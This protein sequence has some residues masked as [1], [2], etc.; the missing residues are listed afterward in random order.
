MV[1]YTQ[2][3]NFNH[4]SKMQKLVLN[5]ALLMFLLF[6][7]FSQSQNKAKVHALYIPLADHYAAVIAYEKFRHELK[8]ADFSIERM[9]NWDLLKAR[10]LEGKTDMAF[11]MSPLALDMYANKPI[12]KWV[13]LMHRDGNGLAVNQT[14]ANQLRLEPTRDKRFPSAD[15]ANVFKY[16]IAQQKRV[17]VGVP[18]LKSTHTVALYHYLKEYNLQL[19]LQPNINDDVLAI[20]I[21]PP[22]SPQFLAIQNNRSEPAAIEQSLPWIDIVETDNFGQLVWYSKDILPS[23]HGHVECIALASNYA[24]A[25]KSRAVEET[26]ALIKKAGA[27]IE[28][29]RSSGGEELDE[30]IKLVQKHIPEHSAPAIKASLDPSLR[31]INYQNLDIDI[32]GLQRIMALALEGGVIQ[33]EVD[34]GQFAH[35]FTGSQQQDKL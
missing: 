20:G 1:Y 26:F 10:F 23:E 22:K 19:S 31:V 24:L 25:T 30:I 33:H 28:R 16:K 17:L 21:A 9:A 7:A 34:L 14:I 3:I 18:H 6:S 27:L 29:A 32:P 8:Y 13:G 11:V 12:F 35:Q 15:L 2:N 4:R 5:T